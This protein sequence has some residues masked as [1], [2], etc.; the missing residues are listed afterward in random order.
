MMASGKLATVYR[1]TPAE[2]ADSGSHSYVR[3]Y[4]RAEVHHVTIHREVRNQSRTEDGIVHDESL[5]IVA[6]WTGSFDLGDRIGD[7]DAPRW[8]IVEIRTY[9]TNQQMTVIPC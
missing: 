6:P 1:W 7:A 5:R 4:R 8:E 2:S 9:L 3:E